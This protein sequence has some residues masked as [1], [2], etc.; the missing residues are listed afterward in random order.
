M[1]TA[2][3]AIRASRD[4][5]PTHAVYPAGPGHATIKPR[6]RV[7]FFESGRD[8]LSFT[9]STTVLTSMRVLSSAPGAFGEQEQMVAFAPATYFDE[10]RRLSIL[11]GSLAKVRRFDDPNRH[12]R[13]KVVA[14][15]NEEDLTVIEKDLVDPS[16]TTFRVLFHSLSLRLQ[17]QFIAEHRTRLRLDRLGR[18]QYYEKAAELLLR[19]VQDAVSEPLRLLGRIASAQEA[20]HERLADS[21]LELDRLELVNDGAEV[22]RDP[23]QVVVPL[24]RIARAARLAVPRLDD[25][26]ALTEDRSRVPSVIEWL[27]N[28]Q[29]VWERHRW[30][31]TIW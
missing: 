6:S 8:D 15:Q 18:F 30:N 27:G 26:R 1:A 23:D 25:L 21:R 12:F 14:F 16:R 10:P 19:F 4:A 24:G 29:R 11:A 31:E 5:L 2:F 20:V 3:V 28:D 9:A 7:V 13:R 17:A 22:A